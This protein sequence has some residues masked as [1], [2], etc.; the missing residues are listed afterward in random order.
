MSLWSCGRLA[1]YYGTFRSALE[2]R[3]RRDPF[4]MVIEKT[5][6][7]DIVALGRS[8]RDDCNGGAWWNQ[9]LL[10]WKGRFGTVCG[11]PGRYGCAA[12]FTP[13]VGGSI[14]A[15]EKLSHTEDQRNISVA[16]TRVQ[17]STSH[18]ACRGT[19]ADAELLRIFP[20]ILPRFDFAV[21][22]LREILNGKC[23]AEVGA[24]SARRDEKVINFTSLSWR[25]LLFVNLWHFGQ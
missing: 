2:R 25:Q 19:K 3:M 10:W 14:P 16:S 9:L 4:T 15:T 5:E 6:N 23:A 18:K 11:V 13:H 12:D 8:R 20:G 24:F 17:Y 1:S 22:H 21:I 7:V